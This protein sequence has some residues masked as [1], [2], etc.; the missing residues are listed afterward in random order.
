MQMHGAS[1]YLFSATKVLDDVTPQSNNSLPNPPTVVSP[2]SPAKK[3]QKFRD[4]G[5]EQLSHKEGGV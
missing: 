5:D 2:T 1:G 3:K 4:E